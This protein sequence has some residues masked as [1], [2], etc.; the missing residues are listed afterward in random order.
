[1]L[2]NNSSQNRVL[3]KLIFFSKQIDF[4]DFLIL[5]LGITY[6]PMS[7][8]WHFV[9]RWQGKTK[10]VLVGIHL[11]CKVYCPLLINLRELF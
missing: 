11:T 9:S 6:C 5:V 7:E 1:M 4:K 2:E 10:N 3:N 8:S